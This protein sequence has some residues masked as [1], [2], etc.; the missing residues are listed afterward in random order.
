MVTRDVLRVLDGLA[1]GRHAMLVYDTKDRKEEVLFS[2]LKLAGQYDGAVYV[3]SEESPLEARSDMK[4][5]GIDV[6]KREKEG[7]LMVK[8]YDQVYIV[9]DEVDSPNIIKGFSDLAFDYSDRGYGMRAA[10]EMSCFFKTW[11]LDELVGYENDLHRKFSFPAFGI[12][13]FNL[14]D[15]YQTNTMDVLWP[16]IKAHGTVIMTGP[17]GSFALPPEEVESKNVEKTM[18]V[19]KG[20]FKQA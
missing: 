6:E 1:P 14:L 4:K 10:A 11:K 20:S 8:N 13:G 5:F 9:N 2:H 16:I 3:C 17:G 7:T 12:C 19:A 18:G 15:M